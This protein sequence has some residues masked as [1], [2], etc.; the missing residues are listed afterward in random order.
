MHSPQAG[1][2]PAHIAGVAQKVAVTF[3]GV[4]SE[5]IVA[6]R[7][8]TAGME[9]SSGGRHI[10]GPHFTARLDPARA[11]ASPRQGDGGGPQSR[12]TAVWGRW[13]ERL[14][15]DAFYPIAYPQMLLSR[16]L[17]ERLDRHQGDQPGVKIPKLSCPNS[18]H[19]AKPL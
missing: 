14:S 15:Q 19:P 16:R 11:K 8:D 9:G 1:H 18:G 10:P 4:V 7:I 5:R 17:E 2:R 13:P 3:S 12:K 6:L